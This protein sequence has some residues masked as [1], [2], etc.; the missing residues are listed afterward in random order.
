MIR[1]NYLNQ[2]SQNARIS[3]CIERHSLIIA[4]SAKQYKEEVKIK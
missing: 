1:L 3:R 4:Y 2:H